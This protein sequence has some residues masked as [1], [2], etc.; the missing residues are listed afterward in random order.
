MIKKINKEDALKITKWQY[1]PPYHVYNMTNALDELVDSY[2]GVYKDDLVGF[3][4]SG[5]D[6][7][8]PPGNYTEGFIDLGIGLRP[9]LCGQGM[10][11]SFMKEVMTAFDKPLRLTVY[12]WNERAIKLYEKLGFKYES[13]FYRGEKLFIIMTK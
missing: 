5:E 12:K 7:Q 13:E 9:D 6:A 2:Y 11:A 4:C 10:G 8:V 1:L 3:F